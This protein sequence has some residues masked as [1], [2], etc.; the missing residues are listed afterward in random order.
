MSSSFATRHIGLNDED[1]KKMLNKLD[2]SSIYELTKDI[3]PSGIHR[4]STMKLPKAI[5]EN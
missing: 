1:I 4:K 3:L 2:K 5:R